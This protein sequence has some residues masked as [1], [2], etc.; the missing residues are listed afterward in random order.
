MHFRYAPLA[1]RDHH[2]AVLVQDGEWLN[3]GTVR[4][5]MDGRFTAAGNRNDFERQELQERLQRLQ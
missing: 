1:I 5:T 4:V 2:I 3:P